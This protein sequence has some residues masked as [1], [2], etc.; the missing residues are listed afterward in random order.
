M[1]S[2]GL[3]GPRARHASQRMAI[4]LC[5]R[6]NAVMGPDR[7]TLRALLWCSTT[8]LQHLT[9]T[10]AI[11]CVLC[12]VV[13]HHSNAELI[14]TTLS[15]YYIFYA[16]KKTTTNELTKA[17]ADNASPVGY[18]RTRRFQLLSGQG[19]CH[20]PGKGKYPALVDR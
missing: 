4:V 7:P 2:V 18:P 14:N 3:S 8:A 9:R 11:A 17:A 20:L 16:Q 15:E 13:K 6:R 10:M 12:L 1:D 5:K 19:L